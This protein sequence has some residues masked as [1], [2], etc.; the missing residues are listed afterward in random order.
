[1]LATARD[2]WLDFWH[3]LPPF[4]GRLAISRL[5]AERLMTNANNQVAWAKLPNGFRV[6]VD[7]RWRG[8][9]DSLYYFRTYE[10][11][12]ASLIRHAVDAPGATFIDVGANVGVFTFLV[13]DVLRKRN[14]RALAIEPLPAN[15]AFL[16]AGIAANGLADVVDAQQVAVGDH[17]GELRIQPLYSGV[18]A[19]AVPLGW[20]TSKSVPHQ[21]DDVVVPMQTLDALTRAPGLTNVRFVKIDIEGA[22]LFALRGA[23]ELLARDRPLVYCEFHREYMAINGTSLDDILAFARRLDYAVRYLGSDGHLDDTPQQPRY[24]DAVLVPHSPNVRDSRRPTQS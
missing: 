11:P 24:L 16:T 1:M 9:Y 6:Q 21:E 12:L 14:G 19:N 2:H 13:A 23:E 10:Q 7:L 3:A 22:E 5:V 8:G 15:F 18:I 20:R 17:P 4:R